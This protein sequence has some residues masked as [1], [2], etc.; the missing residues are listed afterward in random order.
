MLCTESKR[1]IPEQGSL[2]QSEE[3]EPEAAQRVRLCSEAK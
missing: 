3:Y 2:E 1:R